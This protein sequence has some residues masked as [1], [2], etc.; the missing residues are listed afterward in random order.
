MSSKNDDPGFLSSAEKL[1]G[2]VVHSVGQIV[3]AVGNAAQ[4]IPEVGKVLINLGKAM[5]G[6]L[7]SSRYVA[8]LAITAVGIWGLR[9]FTVKLTKDSGA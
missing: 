6:V 7:Q 3:T 1:P 5:V 2:E 4:E 9:T 8:V